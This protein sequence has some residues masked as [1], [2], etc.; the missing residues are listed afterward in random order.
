MLIIIIIIMYTEFI[1][2]CRLIYFRAGVVVVG[3]DGTW[4]ESD[5][6]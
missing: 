3:V 5:G 6:F 2:H 4:I 1:F